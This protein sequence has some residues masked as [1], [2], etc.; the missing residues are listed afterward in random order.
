MP[1]SNVQMD[2][3]INGQAFGNV[4]TRLLRAGGDPKVLRPFIGEDGR[5]YI[6]T[7]VNGK[8][9]TVVT[10]APAALRFQDWR[11]FDEAIMPVAKPRLKF[12]GDLRSRGLSVNLP[13]GMAHT[14][15][16]YENVSDISPAIAS[17]SP[18]RRSEGDR[19]VFD[20]VNLP[21]PIIHKDWSLDYRQLLSSQ[22]GGSPLDTTMAS[23][24][25]VV[26]AEYV[27]KLALGVADTYVF[28]GATAYGLTNFT[29]RLT[30]TITSPTTGGWTPATTVDEVLLMKGQAQAKFHFGPY[31]LYAS[32][33][34]DPYL[35]DDYSAAKGDLTLRQRLAQIDG[36]EGVTTLDYLQFIASTPYVLLLVEMSPWTMREVIGMDITNV[37]W[38]SIDGFTLHF[39]TMC[40]MVPQPRADQNGNCG[41]VHGSAAYP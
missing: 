38:E 20:I 40:I 15:Y 27:E 23:L 6:D 22:N 4:A 32:P 2:Y 25:A 3:I 34:L 31:M 11:L 29:S 17:M 39:K 33:N 26:V 7:V 28:A 5:S 21:L 10:N 8:P 36:I 37:S 35:D 12:I 18:S 14:V 19:P 30:R 13:N 41:I 16:S 1:D 9:S 24:A